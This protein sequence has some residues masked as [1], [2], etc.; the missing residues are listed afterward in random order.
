[1]WDYEGIC[2]GGRTGPPWHK[3]HSP[4][5][6]LIFCSPPVA[7]TKSLRIMSTSALTDSDMVWAP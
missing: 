6:A 3:G 4:V 1:M 2:S 5:A 7:A